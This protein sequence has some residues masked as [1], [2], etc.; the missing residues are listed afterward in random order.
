MQ[1]SCVYGVS[2][3]DDIFSFSLPQYTI[4]AFDLNL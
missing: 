1:P 2:F 3:K 4:Y